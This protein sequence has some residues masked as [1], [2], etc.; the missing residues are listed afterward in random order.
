MP[1]AQLE[2]DSKKGQAG[3][4]NETLMFFQFGLE[5]PFDHRFQTTSDYTCATQDG[6]ISG[7]EKF[8]RTLLR[9]RHW[10]K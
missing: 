1:G 9:V 4:L 8:G 5:H 6:N 2:P 10:P 7:G 3:N